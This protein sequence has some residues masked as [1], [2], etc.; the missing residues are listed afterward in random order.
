M[1][2]I[3]WFG[4][5]IDQ[6]DYRYTIWRRGGFK[7]AGNVYQIA[8]EARAPQMRDDRGPA[9]SNGALPHPSSRP[10]DF[11]P[12]LRD[13]RSDLRAPSTSGP[14][15]SPDTPIPFQEANLDTVIPPPTSREISDLAHIPTHEPRPAGWIRSSD[16]LGIPGAESALSSLPRSAARDSMSGSHY[17]LGRTEKMKNLR[18]GAKGKAAARRETTESATEEALDGILPEAIKAVEIL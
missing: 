7:P 9:I 4:N 3:D 15:I 17:R 8:S 11:R 12:A 14:A 5:K 16:S 2:I 6:L 1:G 10:H 13:V 18:E